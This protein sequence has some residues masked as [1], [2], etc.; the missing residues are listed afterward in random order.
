M[1]FVSSFCLSQVYDILN[2]LE[3]RMS[4][5]NSAVVLA[6][7]KVF[8]HHT[9]SM[10]ATHQQVIRSLLGVCQCVGCARALSLGASRGCRCAAHAS[11][12]WTWVTLPPPLP[13]GA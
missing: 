4:H 10:T 5:A 9:L 7:A 1:V 11:A 2:A 3:G 13:S 8:L 12:W 6:T